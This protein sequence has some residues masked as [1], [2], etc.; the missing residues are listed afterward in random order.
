MRCHATFVNQVYAAD[1]SRSMI[2]RTS[3]I[4][5]PAMRST[6]LSPSRSR[7]GLNSQTRASSG[8][9]TWASWPA[10]HSS[11]RSRS[12]LFGRGV[13]LPVCQRETVCG[14]VSRS[15]AISRALMPP[16][17]LMLSSFRATAV[18]TDPPWILHTGS[19]NIFI[20]IVLN[21]AMNV[22]EDLW[23][24]AAAPPGTHSDTIC[25]PFWSGSGGQH[26]RH[27]VAAPSRFA[28]NLAAITD[29]VIRHPRSLLTFRPNP[30]T[31][32]S[33]ATN[34]LDSLPY[35]PPPP[36]TSPAAHPAQSTSST[37]QASPRTPC[38]ATPYAESSPR[39]A[40]SPTRSRRLPATADREPRLSAS[41]RE[42]VVLPFG[43]P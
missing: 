22:K 18:A 38:S 42:V 17:S 30:L 21:I 3:S 5:S 14:V 4:L 37:S 6:G 40:A 41:A 20:Y 35:P 29:P 9:Y 36:T 10:N 2:A 11:R 13:D 33:P 7:C 23:G 16:D 43:K 19:V 12:R 32:P 26:A 31:H 28:M 8:G 27:L 34:G 1:C 25:P 15:C 24:R 39:R